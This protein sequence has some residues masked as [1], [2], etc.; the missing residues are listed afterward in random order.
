MIETS[1]KLFIISRSQ[2][3]KLACPHLFYGLSVYSNIVRIL[4]GFRESVN[5]LKLCV[6]RGMWCIQEY[7]LKP[8]HFLCRRVRAAQYLARTV[9]L[10]LRRVDCPPRFWILNKR[11]AMVC[12]KLPSPLD[13]SAERVERLMC[14]GPQAFDTLP[15]ETQALK[16]G[17]GKGNVVCTVILIVLSHGCSRPVCQSASLGQVT[18]NSHL[19]IIMALQ[20]LSQLLLLIS[21]SVL[22]A[23]QPEWSC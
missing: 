5:S 18:M 16:A 21:F 8:R 9:R 12:Q 11:P 10:R 15:P 2:V 1:W 23:L 20:L 17:E 3:A 7:C 4:L 19:V 6:C 22:S 14:A 13:I